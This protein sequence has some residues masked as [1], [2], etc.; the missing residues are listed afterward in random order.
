MKKILAL[1]LALSMVFALCACGTT[2]ETP[3]V[4]ESAADEA[5]VDESADDE[6]VV[7]KSAAGEVAAEESGFQRLT[8][9][10]T[11]TVGITSTNDSFDPCTSFF[12]P[13]MTLVYD[14][15][16]RMDEDG[17]IVG[18]LAEEFE[19]QDTTHIYFKLHEATF[20]NGDP[21]TSEDVLWTLERYVL[22]SSSWADSVS[23]IDFDNCEIINDREFVLAS[24]EEFG[25][26]L[27]YLATR[28]SYILNKDYVE[29][30][31]DEAMW[32]QPCGSGPY[33]CTS[34][35]SGSLATFELRED[36][37]DADNIPEAREITIRCYS[38]ATTMF[39]D[40]ENGV[41]DMAFLL[42]ES[43]AERLLNGEVADTNY[44]IQS[45]LDV[46]GFAMPE[47]VDAFDDLRVRQ[48][49]AMAVDWEA[50]TE[51]G[52]GVLGSVADSIVPN[53]VLYHK[54]VGTYEYDPEG[55]KALLDEAGFDYSQ[56]FSLVVV[57]S[58]SNARLAEAI[59][60]YLAVVG[61][62]MEVETC[63]LATAITRFMFCQTDF[64]INSMGS[65]TTLDPDSM[66][67]TIG[68]WSQNGTVSITSGEM[69]E[70]MGL[71]LTTGR[72]SVDPEVREEAYANAQ[73]WMYTYIRQVAFAEPYYCYCYRP[74]ISTDFWTA[75]VEQPNLRLVEFVD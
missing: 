66:F 56:V 75:S 74:Y 51:I 11:L 20:S 10:G 35:V 36:Y 61:I 60:A 68:P 59:Q 1:L 43:D 5:V 65:C 72:Y 44:K 53:G 71:Y 2:E 8:E 23:F 62:Q 21:V 16:L 40:Y 22:T 33:V 13:G 7:D 26:G 67:S 54:S 15:L 73:E 63:D 70:D 29:S 34:N 57:N 18:E 17:N 45:G 31:D 28:I 14:Q 50:V 3:A 37:W 64:V 49:I 41:L 19:Y 47:Y 55:A 4:D 24:T 39:I 69:A 38:E 58:E 48:A 52:M 42:G 46:Y 25:P 32:D 30:V 9:E 12:I 27:S 6:V